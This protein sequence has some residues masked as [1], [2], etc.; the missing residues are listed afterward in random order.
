MLEQLTYLHGQP[1]ARGV[2]KAAPS[3]FV[4]IE[5]L[6][7]EP[8][9]EGEHIFVRVRKTG[10]NTAW[11]AGLLAD[12]AG[13]NR[14]AVTWAGLKD[15][16][17]VTEQWFGI[18]LPGKAEP[19]L[20]VI[21]SDSIQILETRR[22][23]RKL[24]T[25]YLKGNHFTLRLTELEGVQELEAR[26]QAVAAQGVPNYYGE[27]RFGRGGNNLEAAKAMF[28]GKR[29][30]D[31]NK[32]SLYLSAARSMLFNTVV[33]ARIEQGLAHTLLA[34]DCLMLKGSHSIFSESEVTPEL[35]ARL[36]SGDVQLTAPL[37]GRGRLASQGEAAAFEERALSELDLWREGL[38]KAGL[39][40]ERR[41]LLLLPEAMSWQLEGTSLTLS[42]FLPAGAFATSVV[43][44]LLDATE[45]DHHAGSQADAHSGE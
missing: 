15:R 19:D 26:L 3:D 41:P 22:H 28:G 31:R 37:W 40:Q 11:V 43:R 45:A 36:A 4:V 23:N 35:A 29:I 7:F 25:G 14:N 42:F 24:R 33:T 1:T 9:G 17:A 30:K 10:E 5:D 8:C 38:E 32:R 12:A 18:H 2:L 21:A 44:E 39:D 34:G 6:G 13:V 16:H 27:Q 20:R